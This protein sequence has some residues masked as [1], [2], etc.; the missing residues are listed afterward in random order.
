MQVYL[1]TLG[2]RLNEAE[3]ENWAANLQN[4]GYTQTES[5][6]DAELYILNT[7]AVTNEACK[8]SRQLITRYQKEQPEGK[9]VL[10]GCYS[11]L[12]PDEITDKLGVDHIVPNKHKDQLVSIITEKFPA[13]KVKALPLFSSRK[14]RAFIKVQDGCR[15]RCS[16]CIVTVARGQEK[17][18]PVGE[19]VNEIKQLEAAGTKEIIIS[20]V[21]LGGYGSDLGTNLFELLSAI[22]AQT[23]IPRIR[24]GSLE[25]WDIPENF[26][27]LW[28]NERMMP[29]LHLPLQ[30]GC[31]SVLKRMSRR[32]M[33]KEF[34]SLIQKA[35]AGDSN[36]NITTDIIVGFPGETEAEFES[37]LQL[38]ESMAFGGIHVFAYSP[39]SGTRAASMPNQIESKVKK[40]RSQI[41]REL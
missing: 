30:S 19:V 32:C 12:S 4:A 21:H 28:Q 31:D 36:F 8:K 7:C 38:I 10:S 35:K 9:V 18:K 22:L 24:L 11:T 23:N 29:H 5:K 33:T 3:I 15:N 6:K 37:S 16:Y 25:P 17:S 27:E 13:K 40:A 34:A 39:R 14:T 20:G 26:F 41:L 2:C 1:D